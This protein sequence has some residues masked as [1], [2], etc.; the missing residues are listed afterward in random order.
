M[1]AESVVENATL[2]WVKAQGWN[3]LNGA[4]IAPD[5]VNAERVDYSKVALARRLRE[6]PTRLNST[7]PGEALEDAFRR[8][9][10]VD[11][12]TLETRNRSIYRMLTEG[13]TEEYRHLDGRT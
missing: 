8:V 10:R 5:A 6:A 12:A 9:T 2:D 3:V 13:V 1:F 7:L 11:G 4:D